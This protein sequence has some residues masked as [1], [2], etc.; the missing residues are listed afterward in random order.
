MTD[1]QCSSG[2]SWQQQMR[3]GMRLCIEACRA[4]EWWTKCYNEC[5]FSDWCDALMDAGVI[6]PFVGLG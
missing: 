4:N 2:L 1:K 6:D 5:P 3:E